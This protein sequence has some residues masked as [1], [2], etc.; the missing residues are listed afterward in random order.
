[1][2]DVTATVTIVDRD[3]LGVANKLTLVSIAFGNGTDTYPSGGIPLGGKEQFGI[4]K[5]VKAVFI[6]QPVD[7]YVYKI[8]CS[9]PNNLK[10]RIYWAANDL[11]ILGGTTPDTNATIGTVASDGPKLVKTA[12]GDQTIL[13]ANAA[14]NGGVLPGP[15][16]EV[17]TTFA[18]A[19]TV[20]KAMI[21]GA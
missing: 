6:D 21:V 8:D 10:L 2:P 7:G 13:S 14:T 20:L 16:A 19:A 15:L 18:P 9:N 17:P 12:S 11:K 5:Q 4:N 1:M 3:F